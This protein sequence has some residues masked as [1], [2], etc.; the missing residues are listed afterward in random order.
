MSNWMNEAGEPYMTAAELRFEAALDEQAAYD[1]MADAF[2][3]DDEFAPCE[4]NP[5]LCEG[6]DLDRTEDGAECAWCGTEWPWPFED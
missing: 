6:G 4:R 2:Y 5:E 3:A 1:R